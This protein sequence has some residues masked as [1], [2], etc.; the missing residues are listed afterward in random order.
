LDHVKEVFEDFSISRVYS[1]S[2][3]DILWSHNYPFSNRTSRGAWLKTLPADKRVNKIPGSGFLSSKQSLAKIKDY[4]YFPQAFVLPSDWSKFAKEREQVPESYWLLK[5]GRHRNIR[6]VQSD[7]ILNDEKEK[8]IQKMI[9]PPLLIN[10][11]KFDIGTYV[12]LAQGEPLRVFLLDEWLIRFCNTGKQ[13]T[14]SIKANLY[15]LIILDYYPFDPLNPKQYVVGDDYTPIWEIT[16]I[17][18]YYENK[19]GMKRALFAYLSSIG[20]N[21][22]TLEN[23]MENAIRDIWELQQP[24]IRKILKKYKNYPGQFFELFRMDWVI[25]EDANLFLLEVN[26]SPNLSSDHFQPNAHLYRYVIF[27][28]SL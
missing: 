11:R 10:G 28:R 8:F 22:K 9:S 23:T 24:K 4:K 17:K 6:V 27:F 3:W 2:K 12:V 15:E 20:I 21:P 19:I 13:H 26:M 18:P 14:I 25:D 16:D 1:D 5:S 7:E